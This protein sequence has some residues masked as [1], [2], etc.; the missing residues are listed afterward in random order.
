MPHGALERADVK[1]Q[2]P[3]L[4]ALRYGHDAAAHSLLQLGA[5]AAIA[6]HLGPTA[7]LSIPPS[8]D[9]GPHTDPG[10]PLDP[11]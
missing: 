5:K 3:L 9:L 8:P 4:I 1:G 2:T 7:P 10:P 11:R 6:T